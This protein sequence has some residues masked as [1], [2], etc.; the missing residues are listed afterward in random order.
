MSRVD[1]CLASDYLKLIFTPYKPVYCMSGTQ[2]K[3]AADTH[4]YICF[5][6]PALGNVH[7]SPE[8]CTFSGER[9]ENDDVVDWTERKREREREMERERERVIRRKEGGCRRRS[10][11]AALSRIICS[12][13]ERVGGRAAEKKLFSSFLLFSPRRGRLKRIM[14]VE[15]GR[16]RCSAARA[17][18][19]SGAS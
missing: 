17:G 3:D 13:S 14:V 10:S 12:Q 19:R 8:Q 7:N 18:G 6:N 5:C 2:E 9:Y 4:V 16:Y 11:R 15:V 1:R